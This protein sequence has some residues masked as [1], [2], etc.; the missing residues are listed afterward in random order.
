MIGTLAMADF[1]REVSY[2][3]GES[4]DRRM[5]EFLSIGNGK[6]TLKVADFTH[7]SNARSGIDEGSQRT[8]RALMQ[9]ISGSSDSDNTDQ[10]PEA[11]E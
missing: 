8:T 4:L 10:N 9:K 1:L 7:G 2:L 11:V 6:K 3:T 5:S